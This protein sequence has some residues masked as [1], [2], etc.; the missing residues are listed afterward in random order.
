MMMNTKPKKDFRKELCETVSKLCVP[1]KGI[2]EVDEV[3]ESA[4]SKV[5]SSC[6]VPATQDSYKT[7]REIIV[8]TPGLE[9]YI[10]GLCCAPETIV[11]PVLGGGKFVDS[12]LSRGMLPGVRADKCVYPLP[13]LLEEGLTVGLDSLIQNIGTWCTSGCKFAVWRSTFKVGGTTCLFEPMLENIVFL[14]RFASIC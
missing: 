14:S 2:M 6:G 4:I 12:V 8:T 11:T 13:G 10:S 3:Y 5:F 1:G 9:K 7:Y